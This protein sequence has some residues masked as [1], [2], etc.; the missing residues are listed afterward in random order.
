MSTP[1][2]PPSSK[3]SSALEKRKREDDVKDMISKA[4]KYLENEGI[5]SRTPKKKGEERLGEL[6]LRIK[7]DKGQ[8]TD[9]EWFETS[10]SKVALQVFED[11]AKRHPPSRIR[12]EYVHWRHVER[13]IPTAAQVRKRCPGIPKSFKEARERME[14]IMKRL[15]EEKY[16]RRHSN[17]NLRIT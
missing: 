4:C 6:I 10:V 1:S 8:L 16:S 3:P 12:Q 11:W 9:K 7:K 13:E 2:P 15:K 14:K 5:S 17:H